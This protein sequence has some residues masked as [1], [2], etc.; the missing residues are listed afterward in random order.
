MEYAH[1][2]ISGEFIKAKKLKKPSFSA[3]KKE[4]VHKKNWFFVKCCHLGFLQLFLTVG[5]FP[6]KISVRTDHC[7]LTGAE[8]KGA[9]QNSNIQLATQSHLTHVFKCS[10]YFILFFYCVWNFFKGLVA[11]AVHSLEIQPNSG[12]LMWKLENFATQTK[13][14]KY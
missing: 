5:L 14:R 4:H 6:M 10:H 1:W 11:M 3:R 13:E 2:K 7:Q 9:S 12:K 8:Y